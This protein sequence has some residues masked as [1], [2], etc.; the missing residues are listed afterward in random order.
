MCAAKTRHTVPTHG[1]R[2]GLSEQESESI[3]RMPAFYILHHSPG[4]NGT[5]MI[6]GTLTPRSRRTLPIKAESSNEWQF[7]SSD[8]GMRP[9]RLS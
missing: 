6:I 1:A 7:R 5:R 3:R 9:I 4:T 2:M 8:M